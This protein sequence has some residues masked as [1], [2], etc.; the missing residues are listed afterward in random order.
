MNACKNDF[1]FT[2]DLI[3]TNNKDFIANLSNQN[4]VPIDRYHPALQLDLNLNYHNV[5]IC[6]PPYP[7]FKR[8]AY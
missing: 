3:F 6:P 2:L 7:D 5:H 8:T 1:D 4:L